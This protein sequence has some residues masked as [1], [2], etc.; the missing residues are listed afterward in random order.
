M[1]EKKDRQVAFRDQMVEPG[2]LPEETADEVMSVLD[3]LRQCGEQM[4]YS[5]KPEKVVCWLDR[6][7]CSHPTQ[8]D[9]LM[10]NFH[11]A[12]KEILDDHEFVDAED[13]SGPVV[14]WSNLYHKVEQFHALLTE[15]LESRRSRGEL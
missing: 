6:R 1:S 3:S 15:L 10:K 12:I 13:G 11:S 5:I 8:G 2:N 14:H 4:L 9:A 7:G